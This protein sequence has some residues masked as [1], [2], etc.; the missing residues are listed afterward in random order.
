MP[1]NVSELNLSNVKSAYPNPAK[2]I[3]VLPYVLEKEQT[4]MIKIYKLNGQLVEQKQIDSDF[5]KLFLNVEFYQ[6]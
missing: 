5:D 4:S 6:S 2:T 1:N 3:I